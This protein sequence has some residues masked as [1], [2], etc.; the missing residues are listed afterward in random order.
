MFDLTCVNQMKRLRSVGQ[1]QSTLEMFH[2][3]DQQQ[4]VAGWHQEAE[5]GVCLFPGL[6]D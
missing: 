1:T 6:S 3:H 2:D 4:Q 5:A